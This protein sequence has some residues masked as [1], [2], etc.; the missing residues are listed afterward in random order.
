MKITLLNALSSREVCINKDT[1]GGYGSATKIGNSFTARLIESI[2]KSGVK[3]PIFVLGYIAAIFSNKGHVVEYKINE[4]PKDSDLVI[5]PSSIVDYKIELEYARK[6][7]E[8][9]KAKIGFIGPF[10]SVKPEIFLENS[11]FVIKNEPNDEFYYLSTPTENLS[12]ASQQ[13]DLNIA[14]SLNRRSSASFLKRRAC[15]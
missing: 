2:K 14:N 4:V 3:L 11:D 8:E 5:M 10:A 13:A 1:M 15:R 9:T 7:K 6:I 12:G